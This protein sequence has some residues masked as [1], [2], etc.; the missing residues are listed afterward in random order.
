[1][2]Q[3]DAEFLNLTLATTAKLGKPP[4][5]ETIRQGTVRMEEHPDYE[6]A[7]QKAKDAGFE[8]RSAGFAS[9]DRIEF[10]DKEGNLL[11][12]EKVLNVLQ[13]M[14]YLDL[15]H[16]LGHIEQFSRFGDR[17]PPTDKYVELPNGRRTKAP[18][19]QG[20]LTV[21]QSTITEY[22]NRLVEF[23]RLYERRVDIEVLKEHAAGVQASYQKYWKKGIKKRFSPK[24][25][26]WADKYFGDI[27]DLARQ[28]DEA[29]QAI[30]AADESLD[31]SGGKS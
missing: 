17:I 24:K 27:A 25:T 12:I 28:Y 15:E 2:L 4:T 23:L 13:R 16:E 7:I 29:M 31:S 26:A 21:P 30:K 5:P 8:I 22:H 10:Y 1:M 20:V 11:R 6:T 18:N 19:Q 3:T 9:V 14:R